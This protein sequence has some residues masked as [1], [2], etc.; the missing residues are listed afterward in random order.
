MIYSSFRTRP[1]WPKLGLGLLTTSLAA[2]CACSR[3]DSPSSDSAR[4]TAVSGPDSGF[5][6]VAVDSARADTAMTVTATGYGPLRIGMTVANAAT[7]LKSP[8]PT[9]V[10]LDTACAYVRIAN[11]PAGMRIMVV[12]GLVAR[13]EVDSSEVPTGLGVRVGDPEARVREMYGPR[14][15]TQ[16]HKYLANGHYLTV[17]PV[18]PT[19]SNFRLIFETN[20]QRVTT[21]R[22]GR[23]PE[24]QWLEGCA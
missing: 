11:A 6:S 22:A 3:T 18:P 1:A 15:T 14:L 2:L 19:D 24:V 4:N 21:Y 17:A 8:I 12:R 7:A 5:A 16:P 9:T 23:L 20:G 13:I 10:G